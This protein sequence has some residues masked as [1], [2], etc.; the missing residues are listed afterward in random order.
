MLV[1]FNGVKWQLVCARDL[2]ASD[3]EH[4]MVMKC[5]TEQ[6]HVFAAIEV[7]HQELTRRL[8]QAEENH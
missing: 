7:I 4:L 1:G 6:A 3:N 2:P 5:C 8:D